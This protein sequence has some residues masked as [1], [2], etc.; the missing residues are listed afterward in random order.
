M[1]KRDEIEQETECS[2]FSFNAEEENDTQ[3]EQRR[4]IHI[5]KSLT[6]SA[7]EFL[8]ISVII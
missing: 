8:R 5:V 3:A 2:S 6:I 1:K 7:K 4:L